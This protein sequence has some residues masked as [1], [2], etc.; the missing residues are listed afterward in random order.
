M[1]VIFKYYFFEVFKFKT[2]TYIIK[3]LKKK[4]IFNKYLCLKIF[5]VWQK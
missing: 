2:H 3:Y 5:M 1:G 4:K